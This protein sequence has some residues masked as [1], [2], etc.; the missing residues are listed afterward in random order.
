MSPRLRTAARPAPG[1]T[2]TAPTAHHARAPLVTLVPLLL[3]VA[4]PALAALATVLRAL[5]PPEPAAG[6]YARDAGSPR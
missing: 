3:T 2:G 1:P 6:P 4:L 5:L